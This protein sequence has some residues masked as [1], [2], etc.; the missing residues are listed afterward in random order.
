MLYVV[1]AHKR[2]FLY[3]LIVLESYC[4]VVV[5]VRIS[6]QIVVSHT[7]YYCTTKILYAVLQF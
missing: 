7:N 6:H 2:F 1:L 3:A 5:V 4:K